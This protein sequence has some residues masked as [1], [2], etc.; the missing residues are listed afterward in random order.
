RAC[1]SGGT[2]RGQRV[3]DKLPVYLKHVGKTN[4]KAWMASTTSVLQ[5]LD[6]GVI[7]NVKLKYRKLMLQHLIACMDHCRKVPD[8]TT[9]INVLNAI[10]FLSHLAKNV[11][12]ETIRTCF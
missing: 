3:K 9:K 1:T 10:T 6:N 5:P 2:R 11:K 7:Q 4:R 12:G 8:M